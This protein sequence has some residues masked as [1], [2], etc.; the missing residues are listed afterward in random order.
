M[1]EWINK[2]EKEGSKRKMINGRGE[3]KGR[4]L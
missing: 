4:M 1:N 2:R 3:I